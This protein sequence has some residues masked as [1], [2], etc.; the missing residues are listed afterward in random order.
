M[1]RC[2]SIISARLPERKARPELAKLAE[3]QI[4]LLDE[5]KLSGR[6]RRER[7]RVES[8]GDEVVY[9]IAKILENPLKPLDESPRGRR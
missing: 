1:R 2:V 4:K 7:E 5:V 3:T 8:K 6:K 9:C